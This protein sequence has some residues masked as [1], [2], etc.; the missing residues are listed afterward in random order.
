MVTRVSRQRDRP[1]DPS[2][3]TDIGQYSAGVCKRWQYSKAP[4]DASLARTDPRFSVCSDFPASHTQHVYLAL[5]GNVIVS[6][7]LRGAE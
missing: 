2:F 7:G 1:S 3:G 6:L 5:L 4:V